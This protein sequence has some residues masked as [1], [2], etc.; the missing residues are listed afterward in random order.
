MAARDVVVRVVPY[1][2]ERE[3]RRVSQTSAS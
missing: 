3:K 2:E 1:G